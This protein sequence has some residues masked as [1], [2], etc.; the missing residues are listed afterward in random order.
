MTPEEV[1]VR[2][3]LRSW[4]EIETEATTRN[5]RTEIDG[6]PVVRC[7]AGRRS[8]RTTRMMVEALSAMSE[9]KTSVV[10]LFS[11]EQRHSFQALLRDNLER[12]GVRIVHVRQNVI[13][14]AIPWAS[15]YV[16][17][18]NR[19]VQGIT[20]Q[21]LGI[22]HA[23]DEMLPQDAQRWREE[24]RLWAEPSA[25]LIVRRTAYEILLEESPWD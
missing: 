7:E 20:C 25:S 5:S 2:L 9:R 11:H 12:L 24:F 21:W 17:S 4:T 15:V 1:R 6:I 18:V 8:G 19:R 14:P 3:G 23:V 13:Q 10:V 16:Y 22:D